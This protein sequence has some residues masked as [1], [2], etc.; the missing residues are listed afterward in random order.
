MQII[1]MNFYLILGIFMFIAGLT[2]W[3]LVT[4][5]LFIMFRIRIVVNLPVNEPFK[6]FKIIEKGGFAVWEDGPIF[7]K[8]VMAFSTP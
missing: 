3:G 8:S 5:Y 7:K 1:A 6:T 4:K 2:C